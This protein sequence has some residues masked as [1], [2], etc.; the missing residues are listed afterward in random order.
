MC[1]G[2]AC[3]H[4]HWVRGQ[5]PG[6]NPC[7]SGACGQPPVGNREGWPYAGPP[8]IGFGPNCLI[9]AVSSAAEKANWPP[10]ADDRLI[11]C[12]RRPCRPACS[13]S[14]CAELTRL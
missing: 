3:P 10:I 5:P 13:S 4:P 8:R 1:R 7:P 11:I 9:S 14:F 2:E 12:T 6:G